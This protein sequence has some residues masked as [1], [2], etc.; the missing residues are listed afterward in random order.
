MVVW[1]SES[2]VSVLGGLL[3]CV[4]GMLLIVVVLIAGLPDFRGLDH[5]DG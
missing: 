5:L 2:M 3:V 4:S 1:G